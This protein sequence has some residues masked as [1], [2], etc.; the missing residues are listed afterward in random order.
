MPQGKRAW[1]KAAMRKAY[2]SEMPAQAKRRLLEPARNLEAHD[3]AAASIREGIEETLTLLS[4]GGMG[5]LA[6]TLSTTN[7]IENLQGTLKRVSRNVTRWRSGGM[8]LRWA[9]T[10]L[11]EAQ[12]SFRR[13]KGYREL[14]ALL[15]ALEVRIASQGN[16]RT[17]AG[18]IA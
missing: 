3:G 16:H 1:A 6:R 8:A 15:H 14:P 18:H 4:L 17:C 12:K 11:L 2:D 13:L 7:P 9:A 5:A 10:G